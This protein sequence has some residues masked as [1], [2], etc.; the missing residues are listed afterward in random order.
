[1]S[2][3][4]E[5]RRQALLATRTEHKRLSEMIV[6]GKDYHETMKVRGIDGKEYD[7]DI[8]PLNDEEF[9][10]ACAA[11]DIHLPPGATMTDV[12]PT[13]KLF[14]ALAA[15]VTGDPKIASVLVP[16]ETAKIG[17]KVLEISGLSAGPKPKSNS[18]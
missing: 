11:A 2:E 6:R 4:E 7:I 12:G 8:H 5:R 9:V 14:S 18:S 15:A 10:A 16:L 3:E 17:G 13:M 1:M